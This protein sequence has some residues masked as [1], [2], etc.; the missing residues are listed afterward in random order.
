MA[1]S[2]FLTERKKRWTGKQVRINFGEK[3][4]PRLVSSSIK[5]GSHAH[6]TPERK[7]AIVE[8]LGDR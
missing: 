1:L 7:V 8:R 6:E 5:G 2:I 4:L 3:E